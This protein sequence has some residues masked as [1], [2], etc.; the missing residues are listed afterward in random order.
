FVMY[1]NPVSNQLNISLDMNESSMYSLS[2]IDMMGRTIFQDKILSSNNTIDVSQMATG[3]Y[4]IS[5]QSG[6]KFIATKK[7]VKM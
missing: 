4:N 2:V 3:I 5:I 1:P 6:S 7:F